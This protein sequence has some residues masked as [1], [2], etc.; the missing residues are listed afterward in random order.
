MSLCGSHVRCDLIATSDVWPVE[1]DPNQLLRVFNN[2][3]LNARQ[4]MADRGELSLMVRN[5]I[6]AA[7]QV[8]DLAAGNYVETCVRDHGS[9]IPEQIMGKIFDPFFTTKSDGSGLGLSTS[10]AIVR[11]HG[12]YIGVQSMT[13]GG[14]TVNVLLRAALAC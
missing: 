6:L 10:F 1:V 5:R 2:L 3:I 8:A 14:V 11:Q 7:G 12:G 13:G 9:G 4:A